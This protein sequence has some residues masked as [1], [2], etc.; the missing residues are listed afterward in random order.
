MPGAQLL[1]PRHQGTT[2][3]ALE[4]AL[5]GR[6]QIANLVTAFT[7]DLL[8]ELMSAFVADGEAA[9]AT[10]F[11]DGHLTL[12]SAAR[13]TSNRFL[14][15]SLRHSSPPAGYSPVFFLPASISSLTFCPPLWPI[16]S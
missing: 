6:D 14:G 4:C 2:S 13:S 10:S 11:G 8:I 3:L 15:T 16:S 9:L 7:A 5:P 12:R 1:G